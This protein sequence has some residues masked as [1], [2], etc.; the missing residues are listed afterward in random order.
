MKISNIMHRDVQ[1]IGPEE[2]LR[3]AAAMM[4]R[5]D[6]GILPVGAHDKLVGMI[7]DR[8]IAIR[9]VA[10]G[11]GP[12]AK[13]HDVM[14]QE[15]KYCFEDEEVAHVVENMADLQVRRLPVMNRDKRLVGLSRWAI[16]RPKVRCR[17]PPGRC[18]GSR[19]RGV[20]TIKAVQPD[21]HSHGRLKTSRIEVAQGRSTAPLRL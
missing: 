2:S 9:G 5:L 18:M 12:D 14:S 1:I 8:D 16:S 6:A 15:V 21:K 17:K 13:V 7:T 19:S 3:N 11:K 20:S 10:E 4:K